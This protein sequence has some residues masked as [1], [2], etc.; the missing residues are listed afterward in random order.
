MGVSSGYEIGRCLSVVIFYRN[1]GVFPWT[2]TNNIF[3]DI[4]EV[5]IGSDFCIR[6]QMK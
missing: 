1:N 3:F 5:M 6:L 2:N 4:F